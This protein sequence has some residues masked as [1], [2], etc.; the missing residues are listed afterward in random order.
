ML[1]IALG[2]WVLL[3]T[4]A[5][6]MTDVVKAKNILTGVLSLVTGGRRAYE[7]NFWKSQSMPA[8]IA[9]MEAGRLL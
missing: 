2:K 8:I 5:I 9:S 6:G 1:S 4:V 7:K 3:A